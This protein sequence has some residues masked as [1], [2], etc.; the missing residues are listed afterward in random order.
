MHVTHAR[1]P[2]PVIGRAPRPGRHACIFLH[3]AVYPVDGWTITV[4]VDCAHG[5]AIVAVSRCSLNLARSQDRPT[6][7]VGT[8]AR[9]QAD[10]DGNVTRLRAQA[11]GDDCRRYPAD[12]PRIVILADRFP[13]T[14][15]ARNV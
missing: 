6:P 15:V 7:C 5:R 8:S 1:L 11:T 10:K 13:G 14:R 12:V 9:N 3:P 4:S 2:R